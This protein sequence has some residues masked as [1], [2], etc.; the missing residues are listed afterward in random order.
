MLRIDEYLE[1]FNSISFKN[2]IDIVFILDAA[3]A[4]NYKDMFTSKLNQY[5][6]EFFFEF[7]KHK[8]K[9]DSFRISIAWF[10]DTDK[11]NHYYTELPFISMPNK[12]NKI[13]H[14]FSSLSKYEIKGSR[15]AIETVCAATDFDWIKNGDIIRHIIVLITDHGDSISEID[16]KRFFDAWHDNTC[17]LG[18]DWRGPLGNMYPKGKRMI[19]IS[20]D[21]YPYNEMEI[22]FEY[23]ARVDIQNFNISDDE[24]EDQIKGTIRLVAGGIR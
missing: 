5:L 4:E 18:T 16:Y 17:S 11:T 24:L 22:D 3:M 8:K 12:K 7:K 13:D 23:L 19:I 20:P 9:I 1:L 2:A 15:T 21:V 10:N 14:Y 6:E